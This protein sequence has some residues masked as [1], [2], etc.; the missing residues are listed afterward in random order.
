[1]IAATRSTKSRSG[2]RGMGRRPQPAGSHH[3]PQSVVVVVVGGTPFLPPGHRRYSARLG[4]DQDV[5]LARDLQ[6]VPAR[7]RRV[8]LTPSAASS[9]TPGPDVRRTDR[10]RGAC[11]VATA[12]PMTGRIE[13]VDARPGGPTDWSWRSRTLRPRGKSA[14]DS[15]WSTPWKVTQSTPDHASTSWPTMRPTRS[16]LQITRRDCRPRET[17][18]P[19]PLNAEHRR[20]TRT[21]AGSSPAAEP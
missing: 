8:G 16:T 7:P 3:V 12:R 4:R 20:P 13:P 10:R 18:S 6:A 21:G 5:R 11:C 15:E 19:L 14:V 1:M 2:P 9:A 17:I